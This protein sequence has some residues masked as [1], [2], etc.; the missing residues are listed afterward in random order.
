MRLSC[1]VQQE[2]RVEQGMV[3]LCDDGGDVHNSRGDG[4][5]V[6]IERFHMVHSFE[7]SH[8]HGHPYFRLM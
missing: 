3:A 2:A 5:F 1:L 6:S 7:G 8:L 4:S